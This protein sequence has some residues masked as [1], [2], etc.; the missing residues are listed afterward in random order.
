MPSPSSAL[1]RSNSGHDRAFNVGEFL[2]GKAQQPFPKAFVGREA[3]L[4]DFADRC[5]SMCR[6]VLRLLAIGLEVGIGHL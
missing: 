2:G 1:L 4:K 3:E 5:R 6:R